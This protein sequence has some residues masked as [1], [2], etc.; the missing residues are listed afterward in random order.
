[1]YVH[2]FDTDQIIWSTT[3]FGTVRYRGH[4]DAHISMRIYRR[5][6]PCIRHHSFRL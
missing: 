2:I 5:Y 1:M 3:K 6:T 4:R